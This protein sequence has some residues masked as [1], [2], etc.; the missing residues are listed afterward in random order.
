MKEKSNLTKLQEVVMSHSEN[1]KNWNETKQE[2]YV[3]SCFVKKNENCSCGH[4]IKNVFIIKN[5]K[6]KCTLQIGSTCIQHFED[7]E[8]RSASKS[9]LKTFKS[10]EYKNRKAFIDSENQRYEM[11]LYKIVRK[12]LIKDYINEWEYNFYMQITGSKKLSEKQKVVYERIKTKL[13]K[14]FVNNPNDFDVQEV[15]QI[16][17]NRKTNNYAEYN[18]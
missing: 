4:D 16:I 13:N 11:H 14:F 6:N 15:K 9:L 8:M 5:K 7:E 12:C 18:S 10:L 17:E 3:Y 1:T 2:W